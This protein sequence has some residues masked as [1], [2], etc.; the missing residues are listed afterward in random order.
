MHMGKAKQT[1]KSALELAAEECKGEPRSRRQAEAILA[2][3]NDMVRDRNFTKIAVDKRFER[4]QAR[5]N[6]LGWLA[7]VKKLK[8]KGREMHVQLKLVDPDSKEA[9]ELM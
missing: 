5:L 1:K 6:G 2:E 4:L 3:M 7:L 8:M 9:K